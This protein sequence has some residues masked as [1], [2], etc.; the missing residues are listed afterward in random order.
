[1]LD[2]SFTPEHEKLLAN[3]LAS[4]SEAMSLTMTQGYLFALICGPN[5]VDVEQWLHDVSAADDKIDESVVFA[6]MALHHHISEQVFAGHYQLPWTA[7]SDYQQ[8]HQW[9]IGFI[10]GAQPYFDA[11][12]VADALSC[13]LKEAL[14]VATEQLAFFS[15]SQSQ[16]S[17]YCD[18]LN[19]DEVEFLAQQSNLACEFAKG[20]AQLIEVVAVASGLYDD[21]DA[22]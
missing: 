18:Q 4:R 12:L 5:A 6:F 19:C 20:Y 14:Q 7:L 1:M 2:F 17:D 9:S 8:R 15:L 16:V 13:E 22:F 10:T 11:L 3:Y 21:E